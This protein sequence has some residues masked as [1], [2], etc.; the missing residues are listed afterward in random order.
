MKFQYCRNCK[1]IQ[2]RSWYAFFN[3]RRCGEQPVII[4]IKTG[5]IGHLAYA[6]AIVGALLL[7]ANLLD[8]DLGLGD[9]HNYIM[10]GSLALAM[11][12][13][14]YEIGREEGLAREKANDPR[15][16]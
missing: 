4:Y 5:V 12:C 15:L 13:M 3:C 2:K 11:I 14:F 16:R 1:T 9:L 8:V 10:L 6:G 7:G